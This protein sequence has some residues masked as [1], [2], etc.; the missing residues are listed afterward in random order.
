MGYVALMALLLLIGL[1]FQASVLVYAA[2]AMVL[3]FG[4]SRFLV[5]RWVR[6]LAAQRQAIRGEMEVGQSTSVGVQLTNRSRWWI[7]WVLIEDV[8][9]RSAT[10]APHGALSVPQ[11]PLRLYALGARQ[12]K[13]LSYT[14]QALRRGLYQIGPTIAETGDLLGLHRRFAVLSKPQT[15][16]VLPRI[17]PIEG[18]DI[19]SRRPIGEIQVTYRS[20]EDPTLVVGIRDYQQGDPLHR[21]HWKATARTGRLHSKIYQPTTV[22]GAMLLLD[23]HRQS[24]PERHEPVRSDLAVTAAAS[25]AH[26][27]YQIGQQFGLVTNGRDAAE[28]LRTEGWDTDHRSREELVSQVTMRE[29]NLTS[30]RPVV[31][32]AGKG[33]EHF[34][35]VHRTLARLERSDGLTLPQLILETQ[36]R[37]PR[38]ATLLAIVQEIDESGALALS[39]LRK[40]GYRIAVVVNQWDDQTYRQISGKLL[41][42]RISAYHLSDESSIGSI[43]RTLMLAR[44]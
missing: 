9:P 4:G 18:Y 8:L 21:I 15:I 10:Q 2:G 11:T 38:D 32:P 43:C 16:L 33:P 13:L 7:P 23:L 37:L 29:E 41:N 28:R 19:A 5:E 39:L 40:Q 35:E 12:G 27:L 6:A 26:T 34:R 31:L 1:V 36:S 24:N 30:R 3:L 42:L 25:I 22:A 20:M 44:S 17:V 14:L